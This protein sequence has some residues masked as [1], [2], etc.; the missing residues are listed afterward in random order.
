VAVPTSHSVGARRASPRCWSGARPKVHPERRRGTPS[1]RAR[2]SGLDRLLH[3]PKLG[4]VRGTA[5]CFEKAAMTRVLYLTPEAEPGESPSLF[6][7]VLAPR[8]IVPGTQMR[9]SRMP[10]NRCV[11][12]R[13]SDAAGDLTPTPAQPASRRVPSSLASSMIPGSSARRVTVSRTPVSS[14]CPS[15]RASVSS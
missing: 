11:P 8:A 13:R 4:T 15:T 6:M 1:R 7:A 9:R 5:D 12:R 14:Q 10:P 2:S 3:G